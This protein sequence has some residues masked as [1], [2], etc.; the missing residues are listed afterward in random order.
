MQLYVIIE[1]LRRIFLRDM[2]GASSQYVSYL[3]KKIEQGKLDF[4]D[5][6]GAS[7]VHL[8]RFNLYLIHVVQ[9]L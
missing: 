4:I 3:L 5:N 9:V 1:L 7:H 2:F 8:L 6:I